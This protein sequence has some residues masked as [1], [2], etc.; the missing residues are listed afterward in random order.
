MPGP[1][2][3]PR[4]LKLLRGTLQPCRD[5]PGGVSLPTFAV[6]PEPPAWLADVTAAAEFARLSRLMTANALLSEGNVTLLAHFSML[7]ARIC[8]AWAAG[9][10][11]TAAT[12][13]AFRRLA[14]DLGLTHIN[15][16]PAP[17]KSNN[18]FLSNFKIR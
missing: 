1:S 11:P 4:H 7:H 5:A 17:P 6:A 14:S 18:R 8:A 10:T 2:K 13:M 15:A 9:T 12:L 16:Q 3:M